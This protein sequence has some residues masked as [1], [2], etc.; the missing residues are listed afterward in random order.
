MPVVLWRNSA[1]M[2]ECGRDDEDGNDR[3]VHAD[4]QA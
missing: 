3:T 4:S 1:G 2:G